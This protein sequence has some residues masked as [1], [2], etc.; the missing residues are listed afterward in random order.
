MS[1]VWLVTG[2]ASGLPYRNCLKQSWMIAI[3][4]AQ[5]SSI[6]AHEGE[7]VFRPIAKNAAIAESFAT[8]IMSNGWSFY[9]L[10]WTSSEY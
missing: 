2:S 4:Q 6:I 3:R 7:P 1:K 10:G 9:F 8:A 5:K